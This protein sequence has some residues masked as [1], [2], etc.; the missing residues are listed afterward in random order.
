MTRFRVKKT[1][2]EVVELV[3]DY[4]NSEDQPWIDFMKDEKDGPPEVVLR[5]KADEV[6]EI[7]EVR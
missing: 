4:V 5:L 2:D 6:Q 3:A 7:D 1:D